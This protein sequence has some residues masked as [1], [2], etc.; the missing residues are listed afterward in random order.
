[1]TLNQLSPGRECVVI[2]IETDDNLRQRL[3]DF[4][5]VPGTLVCPRFRSP[6]GG[7]TAISLRGSVIA[8]RTKDLERIRVYPL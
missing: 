1:M 3:A 2:R 8:L 6:G 7:M 5:M 4:G